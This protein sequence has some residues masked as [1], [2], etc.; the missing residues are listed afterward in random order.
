MSKL[1]KL[2]RGSP[3]ICWLNA[4]KPDVPFLYPRKNLWFSDVFRGNRNGTLL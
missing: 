3:E 2:N 4:F 1:E